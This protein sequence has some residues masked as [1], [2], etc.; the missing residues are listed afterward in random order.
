MIA[1]LFLLLQA[2]ASEP[3]PAR[4]SLNNSSYDP[5]YVVVASDAPN[6]EL[7]VGFFI[8]AGSILVSGQ[9][10]STSSFEVESLDFGDIQDIPVLHGSY[11]NVVSKTITCV[12]KTPAVDF[13]VKAIAQ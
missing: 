10:S 2:Q 5:C 8:E 7:G 6:R 1:A 13:T 12:V 3:I 4:C 11:C 9:Q